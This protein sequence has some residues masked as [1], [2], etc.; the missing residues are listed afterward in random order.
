MSATDDLI[1]DWNGAGEGG[2]T[3][4]LHRIEFD[5]ESLRDGL[6]SP[7]VVT[8]PVDERMRI[9]HVMDAMGID[10]VDIGL[11]GAGGV[12]KMVRV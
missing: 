9:I 4:P 7:S 1:Y 3:K 6:Q 10:T 11:P 8:P 12:V 2:W 5:D